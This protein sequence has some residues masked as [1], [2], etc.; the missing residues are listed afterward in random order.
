MGL[1]VGLLDKKDLPKPAMNH[2]FEQSAQRDTSQLEQ[3][4]SAWASGA[5]A[6][7]EQN[8]KRIDYN[9]VLCDMLAARG[10]PPN[11]HLLRRVGQWGN[12]ASINEDVQAWYRGLSERLQAREA[13]IP[14]TSRLAANQLIEQLWKTATLD[15]A[16]P[17]RVKLANTQQRCDELVSEQAA[18]KWEHEQQQEQQRLLAADLVL[19][20]E[21]I[22]RLKSALDLNVAA[23]AAE[24]ARVKAASQD[25]VS[26]AQGREKDLHTAAAAERAALMKRADLTN[27]ETMKWQGKFESVDQELRQANTAL[28]N[29]R[30]QSAHLQALLMEREK[31]VNALS[32]VLQKAKAKIESE[33]TETKP[34]LD[35]SISPKRVLRVAE[36]GTKKV[37]VTSQNKRNMKVP[38]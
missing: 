18:I 6:Q 31:Q 13:Q 24:V 17:L 16:E 10:L 36:T 2:D 1:E 20:D 12:P 3:E 11:A 9:H 5:R 33:K 4:V 21:K 34:S 14:I 25:A 22:A 15:V 7:F 23:G 26:A 28:S 29:E 37:G 27:Q 32:K 38:K 35:R 8:G 30:I 19:R